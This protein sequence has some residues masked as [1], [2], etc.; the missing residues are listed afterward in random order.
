MKYK[1]HTKRSNQLGVE[2][3]S[4]ANKL[5]KMIMFHLV[6]KTGQDVCY[7]CETKIETVKDLSIEHKI[8]WLD[9]DPSLF[10]DIYNIAFSH[11][12]C[13]TI[14]GSIGRIPTNQRKYSAPEGTSW[15]GK[16][17]E[18]LPI[19]KFGKTKSKKSGI[20]ANCKECRRKMA[21]FYYDKKNIPVDARG[22]RGDC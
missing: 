7:R 12:K 2:Y 19:D 9:N 15:C 5:R 20:A 21:K 16:H 11:L 22:V 18:Y 1:S 4:A 14:A 8:N 10:W 17:K 13:N 6:Q 3:G